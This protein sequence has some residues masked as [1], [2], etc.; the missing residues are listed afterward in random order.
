MKDL[1]LELLNETYLRI[2]KLFKDYSNLNIFLK[3]ILCDSILGKTTEIYI[4]YK[5]NLHSKI[6][7]KKDLYNLKMDNIYSFLFNH[8]FSYRY[9]F[10]DCSI[11]K[12]A[13]ISR[14]YYQK[15]QDYFKCSDF[16]NNVGY[17]LYSSE[18]GK[19]IKAL[20]FPTCIEE[21]AI[22]MDLMGI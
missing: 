15:Y 20:G 17:E 9:K 10:N 13:E 8:K 11:F 14:D 12:Y 3:E 4:L 7:F 21:L 22:K 16:A 2:V 18:A 1:N 5:N 6:I 19:I